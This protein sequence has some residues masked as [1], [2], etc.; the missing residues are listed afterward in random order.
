MVVKILVALSLEMA[1][2]LLDY[3]FHD[4]WDSVQSEADIFAGFL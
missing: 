1:I 3:V 4:G 2:L